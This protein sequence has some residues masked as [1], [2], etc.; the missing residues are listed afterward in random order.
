MLRET[1]RQLEESVGD[2]HPNYVGT[3]SN[4]SQALQ[5]QVS[6]VQFCQPRVASDA[7]FL[8]RHPLACLS[9]LMLK[10]ANTLLPRTFVTKFRLHWTPFVTQPPELRTF[11]I[12]PYAQGSHFNTPRHHTHAGD[13]HTLYKCVSPPFSLS[14]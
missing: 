5:K 10:S 2:K 11:V 12:S 7:G 14:G 4:L 6:E 8:K 9:A 1:L 13:I 3:V